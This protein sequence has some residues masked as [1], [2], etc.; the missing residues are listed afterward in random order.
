MT[1]DHLPRDWATRPITDPDLF[2]DVVDL[3]T[4]ERSRV[5]GTVT[6]LACHPGGR[7]L[8]PFAVDDVPLRRRVRTI[9][10]AV[11]GLLRGL[12]EHGVGDV[13]L[14]IGRPGRIVPTERDLALRDGL[15]AEAEAAGLRLLG[16][17]L[18]VPGRVAVLPPPGVRIAA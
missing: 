7:L 13:V 6:V 1:Y 2:E 14:V 4:T 12:A 9:A 11:G 15:A 17:A 5:Q 18:A 10:R 3:V 16:T 8:Q